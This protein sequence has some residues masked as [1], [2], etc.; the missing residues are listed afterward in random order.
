MGSFKTG[1]GFELLDITIRKEESVTAK[2]MKA[3][4]NEKISRQHSVLRYQSDLYCANVTHINDEH[5]D[6]AENL[7]I[8]M[9]LYN[10]TEYSDS[11]SDK[12][13]GLLQFKIDE[14]CW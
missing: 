10:L 5:I 2:I 6:T 8:A 11:Y 12:S 14:S 3:F 13:D 7:N 4:P 9:R 1:L